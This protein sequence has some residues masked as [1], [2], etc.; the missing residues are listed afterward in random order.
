[1]GRAEHGGKTSRRRRLGRAQGSWWSPTPSN[2]P[3]HRRSPVHRTRPTLV[4]LTG[5][6]KGRRPGRS[7]PKSVPNTYA[8]VLPA[9][10]AKVIAA[11]QAEG[12]TVRWS[13][14]ASTT[15]LFR[16]RADLGPRWA[17]APRVIA[18]SDDTPGPSGDLRSRRPIRPARPFA[19]SRVTCSGL[20]LQ[21]GSHPRR[22][23]RYAQPHA[24][25]APPRPSSLRGR[26]QPPA[27]HL[28][29]IALQQTSVWPPGGLPDEMEVAGKV[30][31]RAF[32][33]SLT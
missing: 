28:P 7:P 17:P 33:S 6:N 31:R 14:T 18:A 27:T 30:G 3:A 20:R 32:P 12:K 24:R 23:P 15:P 4:P 25:R 5:D 11:L 1:M 19:P 8:E 13:A 10:K 2:R 16:P 9:D 22:R 26:Q 29:P 21:R